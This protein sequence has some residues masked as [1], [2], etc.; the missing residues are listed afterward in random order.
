M[1]RLGLRPTKNSG[2][3]W[4]EKADGQN[5]Y[6]ICELKSTEKASIGVKWADIAKLEEQAIVTGK[7]PIFAINDLTN[8]EVYVIMKPELITEVAKY[9]RIGKT[10]AS[11]ELEIAWSHI[12]NW[13]HTKPREKKV[14]GASQKDRELLKWKGK[15]ENKAW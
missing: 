4:I 1:Q 15:E 13:G 7:L 3:G 2:S 9:L 6:I 10:G 14:I 12:D 11:A 8:N 5:D